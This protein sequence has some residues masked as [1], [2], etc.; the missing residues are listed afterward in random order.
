MI[1]KITITQADLLM[2]GNK[3]ALMDTY[4]AL[5]CW[6]GAEMCIKFRNYDS[7]AKVLGFKTRSGIWK[8]LKKLERMGLIEIAPNR[9]Y[10]KGRGLYYDR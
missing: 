2:L 7:L 6:M 4:L 1:P 8:S 3:P 9:I 10:I 5:L